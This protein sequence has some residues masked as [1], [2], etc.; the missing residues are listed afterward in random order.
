M[1][2]DSELAA[3]RRCDLWRAATQA[4]GGEGPAE[5]KIMLVGEQP[6]D[7]E[8]IAGAPFVGPAGR[9]LNEALRLAGLERDCLYVTNA[10]KHFKHEMRGK[11]RLHKRPDDGEIIACRLWLDAERARIEPRVIVA[12]GATAA[13]A[14]LGRHLPVLGSRDKVFQVPPA[15]RAVVTVHPSYLLRMRDKP[16]WSKALADLAGDLRRAAELAV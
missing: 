4:V 5:A 10:V 9:V 1:R 16:A 8:D 14:V 2:M 12:M 13:F 11:R 6:G 7:A 15:A 3:C